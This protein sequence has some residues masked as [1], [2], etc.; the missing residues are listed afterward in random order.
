MSTLVNPCQVYLRAGWSLG[1][2]KDRYVFAGPGGDQVVGRSVSGLPTT[3]T[4]FSLLPPHFTREDLEIISELWPQIH[5][6]YECFPCGFQKVFPFLL[7]SLIYHQE[8]L[9]NCLPLNHPIFLSPIFQNRLEKLGD[10]TIVEYF[11][12]KI[13][14]VNNYCENTGM[15]A[16]GIPPTI[17]VMHQVD[18]QNLKL[19]KLYSF[20]TG[21]LMEQ[22]STVPENTVTKIYE[23]N[24]TIEGAPF[25]MAM[26]TTM[27]TDLK[28]NLCQ[29]HSDSVAR[30]EEILLSRVNTLLDSRLPAHESVNQMTYTNIVE[31]YSNFYW[32]SDQS[33]HWFPVGYQFKAQNIDNSWRLWFYGDHVQKI[34][35]LRTM[36]KKGRNRLID[37][38]KSSEQQAFS[39]LSY[40]MKRCEKLIEEYGYI[41]PTSDSVD[42]NKIFCFIS[43]K[44][45]EEIYGPE[46]STEFY[47]TK[48]NRISVSTFANVLTS[49]K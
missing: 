46:K 43:Q 31:G 2:V 47:T 49:M 29:S 39:R 27:I 38:K 1:N 20:M 22:L 7:A 44:L 8:F 9:Q 24:L 13:L 30:L 42:S 6:D 11:R 37:F 23:S 14:L 4:H 40:V 12:G 48:L 41:I 33:H 32:H 3:T 16:S 15:Q 28:S 35:P 45:L 17:M 34:S 18:A 5:P 19:D 25:N 10:N 21:P 26:M 36:Y